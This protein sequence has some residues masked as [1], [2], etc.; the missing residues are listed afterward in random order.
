MAYTKKNL[1]GGLLTFWLQGEPHETDIPQKSRPLYE[2][3]T[4]K[5]TGKKHILPSQKKAVF[6]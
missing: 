5:T 1:P 4:V 6:P 3:A 2:K